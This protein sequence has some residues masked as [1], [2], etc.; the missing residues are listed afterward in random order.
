MA[1]L[2]AVFMGE[3]AL[4]SPPQ[5]NEDASSV[6]TSTSR[7][8]SSSEDS[9]PDSGAAAGPQLL[10]AGDSPGK[11][12]DQDSDVLAVTLA[13]LSWQATRFH[14]QLHVHFLPSNVEYPACTRKRGVLDRQALNR[15]NS[16]GENVAS[17]KSFA[18]VSICRGFLQALRLSE[19]SVRS[20]PG[21][22]D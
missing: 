4:P 21:I 8:G 12:A 5:V 1:P 9:S 18:P 15:I 14:G 22:E 13:D 2:P 19:P 7:V 3:P 20:F 17:N 6:Q 11:P 10:S 16:Q